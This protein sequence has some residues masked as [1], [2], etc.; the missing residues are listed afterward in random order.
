MRRGP[1]PWLYPPVF[2][3][4]FRNPFSPRDISGRSCCPDPAMRWVGKCRSLGHPC[5]HPIFINAEIAET[6][7]MLSILCVL[8]DLRVKIR[9][10]PLN[11]PAITF[12]APLFSPHDGHGG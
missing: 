8:R 2:V 11:E 1:E 10:W 5:A 6:A 4:S 3:R 7:E 9:Q 12:R